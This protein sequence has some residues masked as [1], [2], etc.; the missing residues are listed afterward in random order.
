MKV[1]K[2]K[3]LPCFFILFHFL[4]RKKMVKESPD[5][6]K[7]LVTMTFICLESGDW[8]FF[9]HTRAKKLLES[10]HPLV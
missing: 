6:A 3:L 5:I 8:I 4:L 7:R 9:I 10:Q 2:T 1:L